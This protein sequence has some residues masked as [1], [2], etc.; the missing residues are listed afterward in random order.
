MVSGSSGP[1]SPKQNY[2]Q[3]SQYGNGF[4][5][6]CV[7][8]NK[9]VITLISS[10]GEC[11][12]I[13]HV[14][15]KVDEICGDGNP[16]KV[17]VVFFTC[18]GSK[19][20]WMHLNCIFAQCCLDVSFQRV[21]SKDFAVLPIVIFQ[22]MCSRLR[23]NT[24]LIQ[25]APRTSTFM[26]RK[27]IFQKMNCNLEC[28]KVWFAKTLVFIFCVVSEHLC[29]KKIKFIMKCKYCATPDYLNVYIEGCYSA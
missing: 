24:S 16:L 11:L 7:P 15:L 14:S 13:T 1:L 6:F 17:K 10:N 23:Q 18:S 4:T 3:S 8:H 5:Q 21:R 22:C 12:R 29:V 9:D 19:V 27:E 28:V 20:S 2:V 26:V 25:P